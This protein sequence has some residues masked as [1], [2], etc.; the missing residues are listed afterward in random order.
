MSVQSRLFS[1][2]LTTLF[3]TPLKLYIFK[4]VQ[5]VFNNASNLPFD[6]SYVL[7]YS[8]TALYRIVVVL[9]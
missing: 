4:G 5:L 3:W 7:F 1:N 9:D 8:S 2:E 6:I